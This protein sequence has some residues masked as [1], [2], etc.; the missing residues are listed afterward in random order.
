MSN[1]SKL[2]ESEENIDE[3]HL[4]EE[5]N[6]DFFGQEIDKNL[7]KNQFSR[8]VSMLNMTVENR[9]IS[10]SH[11][12][13]IYNHYKRFKNAFISPLHIISYLNKDS[14]DDEKFFIADGQHRVEAL[15]KL[16]SSG[17]DR[18]ILY[19]IHD[20]NSE[21]QI[22]EII[23]MLNSNVP[24]IS[25]FP[26]EKVS[27]FIKKLDGAFPQLF[28]A[29]TNHNDYK[30]NKIKLRDE[31]YSIKLFDT[32]KLKE[33]EIFNHLINYNKYMRIRIFIQ[34]FIIE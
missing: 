16:L 6:S 1:D 25:T 27:N 7:Y 10:Q 24:V 13:E 9:G 3:I 15:K 31:L 29:N 20:A 28:S 2:P 4:D 33:N 17:V 26:F 8:I 5:S 11:V 32:I 18:E 19:F 22:R 23:T 14:P 21:E 12:V 30:M 34:F